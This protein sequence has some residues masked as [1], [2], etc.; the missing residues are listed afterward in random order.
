MNTKSLLVFTTIAAIAGCGRVSATSSAVNPSEQ[1]VNAGN[2]SAAE[3]T[4]PIKL[5]TS[6][7]VAKYR[8]QADGEAVNRATVDSVDHID[9]ELYKQVHDR[10]MDRDVFSCIAVSDVD[11]SK[12]LLKIKGLEADATYS[13][14]VMVVGKADCGLSTPGNRYGLPLIGGLTK[15]DWAGPVVQYS[16]Y[17]GYGIDYWQFA[18]EPANAKQQKGATIP[19]NVRLMDTVNTVGVDMP[20]TLTEGH[21]VQDG[22]TRVEQQ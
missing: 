12:S 13:Y 15:S 1:I 10:M 14:Y 9:F 17:A 5:V 22:A 19:L 11:L 20:M 18:T 16:D 2:G 8:T 3:I 4:M 6:Q 21:F 7:A